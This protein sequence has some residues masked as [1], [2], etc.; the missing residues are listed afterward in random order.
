MCDTNT[1]Y[2]YSTLATT[3]Y[4]NDPDYQDQPTPIEEK[5]N[6]P[7]DSEYVTE[8]IAEIKKLNKQH[9]ER[10]DNRFRDIDEETILKLL[11]DNYDGKNPPITKKELDNIYHKYEKYPQKNLT[12]Y[13]TIL[14]ELQKWDVSPELRCESSWID[15]IYAKWS[16]LEYEDIQQSKQLKSREEARQKL[17]IENRNNKKYKCVPCSLYTNNSTVFSEHLEF[18]KHFEIINDQASIDKLF[19]SGCKK[20]DFLSVKDVTK[21]TETR[22]CIQLR[23]CDNCSKIFTRKQTYL[24]HVSLCKIKQ[25]EEHD[26]KLKQLEKLKLELGL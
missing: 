25:T 22:A 6:K 15:G 26:N 8:M 3:D 14:D 10:M 20:T 18:R 23:T 21:H 16:E 17:I 1:N 24:D 13:R 12:C 11:D 9:K 4:K 19:C 5:K 2:N 7:V